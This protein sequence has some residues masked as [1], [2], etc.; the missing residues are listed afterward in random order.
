MSDVNQILDEM[1]LLTIQGILVFVSV[2]VKG[3]YKAAGGNLNDIEYDPD[4]MLANLLDNTRRTLGVCRVL[5]DNAA[6]SSAP[7]SAST[8]AS[9]TFISSPSSNHA[10]P[11]TIFTSP[12]AS[13]SST[14]SIEPILVTNPS[15]T[16]T[17][18][19]SPAHN[20]NQFTPLE[21]ILA[22]ASPLLSTQ[23]SPTLSEHSYFSVTDISFNRP[24]CYEVEIP[25]NQ[26]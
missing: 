25:P 2:H 15:L 6:S 21:P 4:E 23:N 14:P 22:A 11:S 7:T 18:S 13:T 1:N 5:D 17:P 26:Y 24:P 12:V 10:P 3:V 9:I 8:P 16:S 19:L 20:S